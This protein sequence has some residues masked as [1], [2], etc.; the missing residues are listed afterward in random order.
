MMVIKVIIV[1]KG[2]NSEGEHESDTNSSSDNSKTKGGDNSDKRLKV[3]TIMVIVMV[4]VTCFK[5]TFLLSTFSHVESF[6]FDFD[7]PTI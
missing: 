3:V 1:T 4:K 7:V 6:V 2:G 5:D